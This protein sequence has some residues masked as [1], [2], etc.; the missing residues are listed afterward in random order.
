MTEKRRRYT[1]RQ[2]I[3]AVVAAEASSTLAAAQEKGIPEA[4]LRYWVHDPQFA[5]YREKTRAVQAEG[6]TILSQAAQERLMQIMPTLEPRDLIVLAGVGTDKA[7][8]LSGG[9]TERTETRDLTDD[10]EDHEKAA[11]RKAIDEATNAPV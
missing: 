6:W 5:K 2:K 4:T 7:Q 10:F 3:A 1:K 8:L 11:L 9:A